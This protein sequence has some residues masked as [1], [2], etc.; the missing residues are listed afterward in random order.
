MSS[1]HTPIA[2]KARISLA[3]DLWLIQLVTQ[4]AQKAQEAQDS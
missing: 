2:K 1:R 4:E 3:T